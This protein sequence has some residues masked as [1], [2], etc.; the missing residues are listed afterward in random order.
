RG[1]RFPTTH[2]PALG[3]ESPE[4]RETFACKPAL[5]ANRSP[6]PRPVL[7]ALMAAGRMTRHLLP[8]QRKDRPHAPPPHFRY[9]PGPAAARPRRPG[10]PVLLGRDRGRAAVAVARLP[11]RPA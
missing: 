5:R 11:A 10:R 8:A 4:K 6:R 1:M 2:R 7:P 3:K 9:R